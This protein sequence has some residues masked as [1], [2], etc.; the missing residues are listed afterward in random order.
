[1]SVLLGRR[2]R[3]QRRQQNGRHHELADGLVAVA[4]EGGPRRGDAEMGGETAAAG[5]ARAKR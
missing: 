1:M 5:S 2:P 3:A 4:V